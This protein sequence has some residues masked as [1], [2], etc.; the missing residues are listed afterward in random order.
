MTRPQAIT[1]GPFSG[2]LNNVADPTTIDET[3]C[4]ELINLEVDLD[5]SL[6]TRPAIIETASTSADSSYRMK[7]IGRANFTAGGSYLILSSPDGTFAFDGNTITATI[8]ADLESS[9]A[10][11]YNENIY[12]IAKSG[13]AVGGG[14]WDGTT[15][16]ADASMPRGEAAVFH[17]S[18]LFVVPGPSATTNPS[19]L[20]FTDVI[21]STTLS[22]PATNN[23]DVQPGDGEN[24]VD[25]V[26]YND[27]IVLFKENSIYL[28][29]Y[30]ISPDDAVLRKINGNIGVT[31]LHC[32]DTYENSIFFLHEGNIYEMAN[33]EFIKI[34]DKV[35]FILDTDIPTTAAGQLWEDI[36]LRR[37]GDRIIVG[38]HAHRYSFHLLT[39]TWTQWQVDHAHAKFFGPPMELVNT[40]DTN[41]PVK[42][43]AS[44]ALRDTRLIYYITDNYVT[45]TQDLFEHTDIPQSTT[46]I[47]CRF[48]TKEYDFDILFTWK[49]LMWWGVHLLS[50]STVQAWALPNYS[51]L[52]NDY[53]SNVYEYAWNELPGTWDNILH[54]IR[55]PGDAQ[56]VSVGSK[57]YK[58][59]KSLR[60]R[61]IQFQVEIQNDGSTP[62]GPCR[63]FSMVAIVGVKQVV[64]KD[65]N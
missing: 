9:V 4:T 6:M 33:Y 22:W 5:G 25:I 44:N 10:L 12:I 35:K 18:R 19:R 47:V 64:T 50:G 20:T 61:S 51:E 8:A 36:Y 41:E 23:I 13:S 17:K 59:T 55:V 3:E 37:V 14:R 63:I 45:G 31:R 15:F 39:R 11:Q 60:F 58:F 62:S 32:M 57:F 40:T 53:W 26:I 7:I 56:G 28:L 42:Y 46:P 27:N 34:N 48:T 52:V 38:F 21:T 43:Y 49:R 29:A 30:D 54:I 1:L 2:G 16:T 65:S 24:L